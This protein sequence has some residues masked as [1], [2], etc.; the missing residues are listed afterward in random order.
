MPIRIINGICS[1]ITVR[2]LVQIIVR[3]VVRIIVWTI[4]QF[5]VQSTVR[6]TICD[7]IGNH[8]QKDI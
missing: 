1:Q 4:F 7:S 6:T 3:T 5:A 2:T 8:V